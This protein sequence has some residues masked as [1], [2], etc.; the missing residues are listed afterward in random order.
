MD[1]VP[2]AVQAI[3]EH[4]PDRSYRVGDI[5]TEHLE[6]DVV[7]LRDVLAHLSNAEVQQALG[8]VRA[9]WLMATTFEGAPEGDTRTGGYREYD[10]ER[11]LGRPWM[12]IEDGFW[13]DELVYPNKLMG[14]WACGS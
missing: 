13:E 9:T 1:I 12:V 2:E 5:C 4:F 7:F 8:N 3:S 11:T 6:A 14:V 10:L